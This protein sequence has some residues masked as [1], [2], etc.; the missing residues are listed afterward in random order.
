MGSFEHEEPVLALSTDKIEL[1]VLEGQD[2]TGE[3]VISSQTD[4]A[5]KG[6]VYSS[7]P[8]MECLTPQ[9]K[10]NEIRIRYQFHS[11]GFIEGDIQKGDFFII[12]NQGEYNLSF[13]VSVV[14]LYPKMS[15]G[16]IRNL[17]DFANLAREDYEEAYHLFV[18]GNFKNLIRRDEITER[19]LYEGLSGGMR[20]KTAMEEFLVSIRKKEAVHFYAKKNAYEFAGIIETEKEEIPLIKNQWG[21]L[22][23]TVSSDA[24]F[25]VPL[26]QRLTTEDFVGST[27]KLEY[28]IDPA[29]LHAGKNF[30]Q[31]VL[32]NAYQKEE[33]TVYVYQGSGRRAD[34]HT[35]EIREAKIELTKL[36]IGCRLKKIGTAMCA[37][38]SLQVLNHL[39][40][41]IPQDAAYA[42]DMAWYELM[43]AQAFLLSGQRQEAEW[44]LTDF[45]KNQKEKQTPLYGYY[46]YVCTLAEREPGYVDRL[47]RLVEEIYHL[48][49]EDPMLFWI[50]LFLKEEFHTNPASRIRAIEQRVSDGFASPF[51]YLEAYYIFWQNPYLLTRLGDF[52]IQVLNWACRQEVFTKDLTLA[53]PGLLGSVRTFEP[54]LYKV[55]EKVYA[56]DPGDELLAAICSYLVR[57]QRF[58]TRYHNWYEEGIAKDLRIAGIN[59]AYLMSMDGRKIHR[60]PKMIQMYFRYDTS[61][62]YKQKAAL[63]VNIIAGKEEEPEIYRSYREVMERFAVE[64]IMEGHMDDNLA[65]IYAEVLDRGMIKKEL[66]PSLAKILYTRK[67]TVFG[68]AVRA[69]V[70]HWQLKDIQV[71][72]VIRGEAY[73]QVYTKDYVIVLEDASGNRYVKGMNYQLERLIRARTYF[74]KCLAYAPYETSFLLQYFADRNKSTMFLPEDKDYLLLLMKSEKLRK[75]YRASLYAQVL[76]FLEHLDETELFE[77]YLLPAP[78][79]DCSRNDRIYCVEQLIA[80]HQYELA[81][82]YI[83]RYGAGQLKPAALVPLCSYAIVSC[84]GEEDDFLISLTS[85]VF[86][87]GKY[88]V[89]MLDYLVHYFGG[90]TK[91]MYRLWKACTAFE[92]DAF[93]LEERLIV[94]MLYTSEFVERIEDVYAS[95]C[96]HGGS[97]LVQK[98]FLNY[99]AY[100][101]LVKQ[102]VVPEQIFAGIRQMVCE[103][104]EVA[105]VAK[106]A[107]LSYV[108]AEEEW[109]KEKEAVLLPLL[110]EF[111]DKKMYFGFY[112][113]LPAAVQ[114][115]FYFYDKVFFEYRTAPGRRVLLHYRYENGDREFITE[116]M[117]DMFEGI[118]VKD[119][120]LFIDESVEYYITENKGHETNVTESGRL[121]CHHVCDHSAKNRYEQLNAMLLEQTMGKEADLEAMM[122]QYDRHE[123]L[124]GLLFH[125]L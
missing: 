54:L 39:I 80:C 73:F 42:A 84:E 93:E 107:L 96:V 68:Q 76:R 98:A 56:H 108:V 50:R 33:V 117:T 87:Q 113:K 23:I 40:S 55:L 103:E 85:Y 119:F 20:S 100:L 8:H 63:F 70:I 60:M 25:L 89:T 52:E 24:D 78:V 122:W 106:L 35:R 36:Y 49:S 111:V 64:Q 26:K 118:F 51:L 12:C 5:V 67:M 99:F 6:L 34:E 19:M 14:R 83:N 58:S 79:T 17:S 45:K 31:L 46:L 28:L 2:Y 10:G 88:D 61:L 21:Y 65:V 95:Y 43:R 74:R 92:V 104:Q 114:E 48:H 22:E 37:K 66:V 97:D 91:S 121:T 105:D 44:I 1:E 41:L 30:G 18:S 16:R 82:Q 3:F 94:Q 123:R 15:T 86:L 115:Q 101:Y 90:T 109:T 110:H 71:V 13:V 69:Y 32:E 7:N 27:C 11:E 57:T 120:T 29:K 38:R 59:E 116:E 77:A 47:S 112:Q 102:V 4:S 72:P 75:E 9:F 124:N 125:M 81:Y 53:L 62:P